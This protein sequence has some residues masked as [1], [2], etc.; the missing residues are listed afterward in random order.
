MYAGA[1]IDYRGDDVSATTFVAVLTGDAT[2][3][4]KKGTG[5]VLASGPHDRVFLFYS[6]HGAAGVVGMPSGPFLYADQLLGAVADKHAAGGF[7][8]MVLYIEACESGSMFE[9]LLGSNLS[10]YV[11]TAGRRTAPRSAA[12]FRPTTLMVMTISRT[13]TRRGPSPSRSPT[14]A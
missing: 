7:K 8:E 11:T 6:D 5:R 3:V 9:G 4:W 1:A 13:T 14:P 12:A 2:S 10:T